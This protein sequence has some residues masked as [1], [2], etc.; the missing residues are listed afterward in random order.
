MF[1]SYFIRCSWRK[2]CL[3]VHSKTFDYYVQTRPLFSLFSSFPQYTDKI[4]QNLTL[5]RKSVNYVLGI[6]T[7]DCRMIGAEQST[8]QWCHHKFTYIFVTCCCI[9]IY[10]WPCVGIAAFCND[11]T[12][13]E[14]TVLIL[15]YDD[16]I[17]HDYICYL[18]TYIFGWPCGAW[19]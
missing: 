9:N 6:W 4:I 5:N 1:C 17:C 15:C 10:F 3:L 8:E 14:M 11:S 7:W 13:L 16:N 19:V 2:N 12:Y 18:P